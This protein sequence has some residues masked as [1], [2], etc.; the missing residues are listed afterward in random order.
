M[1]ALDKKLRISALAEKYG[2]TLLVLFG[3]QATG[4][5]HASSDADFAFISRKRLRPR[6]TAQLAYEL[7]SLMEFARIDLVDVRDAPPL[8]LRN[9]AVGDAVI[10]EAEPSAHASFRIYAMKRYMEAKRLLSLRA[11]SLDAFLRSKQRV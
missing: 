11:A 1:L 6:E 8:L 5:T 4:K 7:S 10:H 3:S 2:I 9:I